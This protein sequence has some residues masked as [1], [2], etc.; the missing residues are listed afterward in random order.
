MLTIGLH[1]VA[2]PTGAGRSHD[3]GV[4][5]LRDGR[6][7]FAVELERHTGVKHAGD[8]ADHVDELLAPW[9]RGAEPI[10]VALVNTF[11][12]SGLA[13][14]GGGLVVE[15]VPGLAVD[16]VLSECRGHLRT[17]GR[18]EVRFFSVCH[19]LAHLGT[20]LPFFGGFRPGSLLVHLDG[21][22]SRSCASAWHWDGRSLRHLD[23]GWHAPQK[24]AANNFNDSALTRAIL[25]ALP[26]EH[27]SVPGRLMGL[28]SHGA[29]DDD[30]I[31]WLRER[32][33]LRSVDRTVAEGLLRR[34]LPGLGLE[35]LSAQDPGARTL[36]ACVQQDL[37]EAVLAYVRR[38]GEATGAE[39]LYLSGGV[40]LNIHANTR[41][42]GELGF[43]SVQVPPAP[44]D[45]GLA[46]GAA[47]LL[48]WMDHEDVHRHGPFLNHVRPSPAPREVGLPVLRGVTEA[49]RALADG[50]VL[51][52]WAGHAALGPRA[53][54]H[55]SLL[56]RPDRVPL[57]QRLSEQM[58]RREWYR[59][60][61][62]M[63]LP[64][65]AAEALAGLR[66]GSD[67]PRFMLGAWPV[68]EPWREAFAG[69]V[70]ADGTVRA[71][72]VDAGSPGL[73]GVHDL[74]TEL[75]SAHGVHGLINTSF[76]LRGVPIVHTLDQAVAQALAL[77]L[78][79]LWV[80]GGEL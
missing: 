74:L 31:V 76:N 24:V 39:H 57:R 44:S 73:A 16:Q 1:G 37:E 79:G 70:H 34:G 41:V 7:V 10:R 27:L 38:H 42:E 35:D 50:A 80:P 52:T 49:A 20:C 33:W 13:S 61:A 2:D 55:R 63:M 22:A 17:A 40:A 19:E 36:A 72:I 12:G 18:P 28:A 66:P 60:V 64:E 4:A 51:G 32:D 15:G 78:D 48:E 67:L 8:L 59:P 65:V 43:A 54:G 53:L 77:G 9:V 71:Q 29:A 26:S 5:I 25:G 75:R 68:T 47:A 45:A 69:C 23:H 62:P 21:G 58:K 11:F 6:V 3:H 14:T 46:L 30:A 56:A